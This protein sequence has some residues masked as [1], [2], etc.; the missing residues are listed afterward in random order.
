MDYAQIIADTQEL[1]GDIAP[2]SSRFAADQIA[3]GIQW[4]QEQVCEHLGI[5]YFEAIVPVAAQTPPLGM[6]SV[7][8]A[9]GGCAIPSD[10]IKIVRIMPSAIPPAVAY[11]TT[12]TPTYWDIDIGDSSGN[13]AV[14][15]AYTDAT[16]VATYSAYMGYAVSNEAPEIGT[17]ALVSPFTNFAFPAFSYTSY[18]SPYSGLT[19]MNWLLFRLHATDA[20]HNKT[21]TP[22]RMSW[23]PRLY[24]S[25]DVDQGISIQ[26]QSSIMDSQSPT[27]ITINEDNASD[28]LFFAFPTEV[29]APT[30]TIL[31]VMTMLWETVTPVVWATGQN[32]TNSFGVGQS[33][34]VYEILAASMPGGSLTNYIDPVNAW[35]SLQLAYS[36]HGLLLDY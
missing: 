8:G 31:N 19:N 26:S 10:S 13:Y 6:P 36:L 7:P 25:R 20:L 35:V 21:T 3:L 29:P 32:I 9:Y 30:V 15:L 18:P 2:G 24:Y 12:A 34:T 17:Q 11:S 16:G 4:A 27:L 22:I 23:M 14:V 5:S 1:L 28:N 33:Y